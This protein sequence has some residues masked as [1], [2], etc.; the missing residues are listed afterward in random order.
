MITQENIKYFDDLRGRGIKLDERQK[1]WWS[2]KFETLGDL[3]YREHP[4][5]PEEAFKASIEGAY[6]GKIMTALRRQGRITRVPYD[7]H[8]PVFTSWDL[9]MNDAMTIWFFQ[10]IG[11]ELRIIDYE[12]DHGH[13]FRHYALLLVKKG[14]VYGSHY[15]PH[16]VRVK[17]LGTGKTRKEVAESLGIKPIETVARPKNNDQLLDQIEDTRAFLTRAW[18]DEEKCD[19]GIKGLENYRQEWDDKLGGFKNSPLHNWASHSAD[20]IRTGAVGFES[21]II[22]NKTSLLPDVVADY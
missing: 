14:Y 5:Y 13:G 16:D 3:M 17:E 2:K 8:F 21:V 18:I 20:G 19:K 6:Y 7:E 4:S 12:E 10:Q 22:H 11:R 15:M 9:G 1:A